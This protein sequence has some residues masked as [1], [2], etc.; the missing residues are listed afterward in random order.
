MTKAWKQQTKSRGAVFAFIS[1]CRT[2]HLFTPYIVSQLFDSQ[3]LLVMG[4][5]CEVWGPGAFLNATIE[6]STICDC[7]FEEVHNIF[8]RHALCVGKSTCIPAM[9]H[10]LNRTQVLAVWI[11]R[12][13]N[14]WN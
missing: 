6:K 14:F 2:H 12:M 5:G 11:P 9:R 3:T 7:K 1:N 13:L 10:A 4:F 8:M